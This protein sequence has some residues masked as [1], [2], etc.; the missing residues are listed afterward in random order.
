MTHEWN[1]ERARNWHLFRPPA[2]PSRAEVAHYAAVLAQAPRQC[3]WGLLG[4]TP[5]LRSLA[6]AA[7]QPLVCI[8][9]DEMVFTTLT[10]LV[11]VPNGE[12]RFVCSD[13]LSARLNQPLSIVMGDGSINMLPPDRHGPLLATVYD[14]LAPGGLALLRVHLAAPPRFPDPAAVFRAYR[15]AGGGE[16]VFTATRTDL[17]MLWLEPGS[18]HLNFADCHARLERLYA[19]GVIRTEEFTGYHQLLRFNRIDF[20]YLAR[21]RFERLLAP[22][23]DIED[24]AHGCDYTL[25]AQHPLY[26]LR[27]RDTV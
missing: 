14:M 27:R 9:R 1:E 18:L 8:D 20:W 15:S 10:S 3:A 21:E 2:R 17:D 19:Q 11:G 25:A 12:E 13:W 24:I 26:T 5:E 23:F 4:S 7:N 6:A 16:P 22:W